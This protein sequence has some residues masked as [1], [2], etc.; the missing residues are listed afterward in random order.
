MVQR[1][2]E[3][4]PAE[5]G[6]L[7]VRIGSWAALLVVVSA[8]A[9]VL[10][11]GVLVRGVWEDEAY[12]LTVPRN[13]VA[14]LGYASDGIIGLTGITPFDVRVTTGPVVLLPIALLHWAGVEIVLAGR[15]VSAGFALLL[16][17][18]L[19]FV[20]SRLQ[21]ASRA[22]AAASW[23]GALA[24]A[25]PLVVNTWLTS[26]PIQSPADVLGE[27]AAAG[28]IVWALLTIRRSVFSA[29]LLLGLAVQCKFMSVLALPAV[30]LVVLLCSDE[31]VRR[32]V[33]AL[34]RGLA[35]VVIPTAIYEFWVFIALGTPE[36]VR[37]VLAF[38]EFFSVYQ[39]EH[40]S[41]AAKADLLLHAWF[42]PPVSVVL[43]TLSAGLAL[44]AYAL[45]QAFMART[46]SIGQ[47]A[48][49]VLTATLG[50]VTFIVWWIG[51][52]T[53]PLWIRHPAIGL[54]AFAPILMAAA[55]V[56]LSE[57][58][59]RRWRGASLGVDCAV[60]MVALIVAY[61]VSQQVVQQTTDSGLTLSEQREVARLFE[62]RQ[63]S[64]VDQDQIAAQWG[65]P[66]AVAFLTGR[67]VSAVLPEPVAPP[68]VDR[69]MPAGAPISGCEVP[70]AEAGG[71]V[72]CPASK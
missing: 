1:R 18:G 56:S 51:S 66:V 55:V 12:N 67:H 29:G 37:H 39:G 8:W 10:R 24:A 57:W 21:G 36:Y 25:F 59:S 7:F 11:Q 27:F 30:A 45:H 69:I 34:L 49:T 22:E 41:A 20:G 2:A 9:V 4:G 48:A 33:L 68:P 16:A 60:A 62:Q 19:Y 28:L 43:L 47:N 40:V 23:V 13:L 32:R 26:S 31:S 42:L 6:R 52:G 15:L 44:T 64:G 53:T 65:A 61:Q 70:R 72:L 50:L 14:G 58:R 38:V 71:F 5:N 63:V 46:V 17:L 3:G 54:L 35:G